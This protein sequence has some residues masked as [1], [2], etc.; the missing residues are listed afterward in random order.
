MEKQIYHL[1]DRKKEYNAADDLKTRKA[2][3][4]LSLNALYI[5]LYK[6]ALISA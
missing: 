6:P 5:I 1:H 3:I 2:S 4:K